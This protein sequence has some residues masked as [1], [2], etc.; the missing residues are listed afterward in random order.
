MRDMAGK[1]T[2][3][4]IA[5]TIVGNSIFRKQRTLGN[6]TRRKAVATEIATKKT[7][8][9]F[10]SLSRGMMVAPRRP[11]KRN[12]RT[13]AHTGETHLF[14]CNKVALSVVISGSTDKA[15]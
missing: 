9:A 3:A 6:L 12:T 4:A 2:P 15:L 8:F 7:N 1:A 5:V 14:A 10:M 13:E 11:I